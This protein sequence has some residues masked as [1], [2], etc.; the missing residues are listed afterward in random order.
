MPAGHGQHHMKGKMATGHGQQDVNGQ[1]A[2]AAP[3]VLI[4][5]LMLHGLVQGGN[6]LSYS[7]RLRPAP[8]QP[9]PSHMP[10]MCILY[11]EQRPNI[12]YR[13]MQA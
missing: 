7:R 1:M 2:A 3:P 6:A 10:N 4:K 13:T 11:K 12:E 5:G 8:R 9:P